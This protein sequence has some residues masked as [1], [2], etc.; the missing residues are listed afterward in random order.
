MYTWIKEEIDILK[1]F[2]GDLNYRYAI[3]QYC[4]VS[5]SLYLQ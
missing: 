3:S 2:K 1:A 5:S 4:K